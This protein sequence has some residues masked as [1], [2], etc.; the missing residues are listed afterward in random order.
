MKKFIYAK[1][2]D[3]FK[4]CSNVPCND[5][6]CAWCNTIVSPNRGY[7]V[8]N[9]SQPELFS[10][11]YICPHCKQLIIFRDYDRRTFPSPSYGKDVKKLPE[12]IEEIYN[13]CRSCYS[14][15]AY[16]GVILLGRKLLMHIAVDE[17][18]EADKNFVYYVDYLVKNNY[19]PPKIKHLLVFVKN[20]GNEANHQLII[21]N[22]EEAKKL[23]DFI[24]MILVILYEYADDTPKESKVNYE[25]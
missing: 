22:Q 19:I 1:T 16:T 2:Y 13:E 3:D 23:I 5:I 24:E 21:K 20:E 4:N 11:I 7:N 17:G 15:G 14:S 6:T 10:I 18:A 9:S 8:V 25:N 12:D